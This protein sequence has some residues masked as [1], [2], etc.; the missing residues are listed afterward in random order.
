MLTI[1]CRYQEMMPTKQLLSKQHPKNPNKHPKDQIERLAQI[2][3]YQGIRHPIVI[4]NL[5][6]Y[7]TKGHGRLE[8][9]LHNKWKEFPVE[10]QDYE[11]LDQEIA[12]MVAD[13][14]IAKLAELDMAQINDF[15]PD[16][17]PDL[18]LD[19]LGL[20]NFKLDVAEHYEDKEPK[21]KTSF[22]CP[23]CGYEP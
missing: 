2:M 5:S 8:A 4:S 18:D 21:S 23:E 16:L 12:D 9:A 22:K 13:N 7:I 1:R 20:P 15:V 6:G 3:A 10:F 17:G 14:A 11:S 19:L